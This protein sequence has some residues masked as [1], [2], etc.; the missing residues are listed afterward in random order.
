VRPVHA[1][2]PNARSG[3][4]AKDEHPRSSGHNGTRSAVG[5]ERYGYEVCV[6]TEMSRSLP[7]WAQEI[8]P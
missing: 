3:R 6:Q 4:V 8:G 1:I 7:E 2:E 5:T